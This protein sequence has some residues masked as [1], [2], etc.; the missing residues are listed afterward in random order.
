M[1]DKLIKS[2]SIKFSK[3]EFEY[4]AKLKSIGINP[5]HFI[6]VAF[7]E[8]INKEYKEIEKQIENKNKIILPF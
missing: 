7:R 8:K 6:K 4:F 3:K 2:K 1:K 5:N